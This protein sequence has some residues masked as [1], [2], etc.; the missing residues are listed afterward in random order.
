MAVPLYDTKGLFL[1]S[2]TQLV[3]EQCA[4]TK[5]KLEQLL[6]TIVFINRVRAR[7]EGK[8]TPVFDL[9]YE[10]CT[11]KSVMCRSIGF[12][13]M[14]LYMPSELSDEHCKSINKPIHD[15]LNK[16]V[17]YMSES[18]SEKSSQITSYLLANILQM[19][20]LML[21]AVKEHDNHNLQSEVREYIFGTLMKSENVSNLLLHENVTVRIQTLELLKNVLVIRLK[22]LSSN[23]D[24]TDSKPKKQKKGKKQKDIFGISAK[25]LKSTLN[26]I[27]EMAKVDVR[28]EDLLITNLVLIYDICEFDTNVEKSCINDTKDSVGEYLTREYV[29]KKA[30]SIFIH[31][32]FHV[33]SET[34]RRQLFY[35]FILQILENA[36]ESNNES[37]TKRCLPESIKKIISNHL[38]KDRKQAYLEETILQIEKKI[39]DLETE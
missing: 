24:F 16:A 37:S 12:K 4:Q 35:K 9:I 27:C 26:N 19:F 31:E 34:S 33:S 39:Q 23:D 25:I 22:M 7:Q 32:K 15:I 21:E 18:D 38:V 3:N 2:T 13:L 1:A 11:G 6:K 14:T 5:V 29:H 10:W 28:E 17:Q 20:K 8:N 36:T 30:R